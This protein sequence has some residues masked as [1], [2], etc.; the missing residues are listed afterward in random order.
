MPIN[1]ILHEMQTTLKVPKGQTNNFGKYKYRSCEDIVEA[2]KKA[3][4]DGYAFTLS[5]EIVMIG[6]RF[7]I[8]AQAL[9]F[10]DNNQIITYGYAREAET[11]KGMDSAQITG[12]A[13]SY[14]RK[15]ALNGLFAID[16]TKDAD[17]NEFR[18][19][20]IEAE[21]KAAAQEVND[22]RKKAE[23]WVNS[24]LASL[25]EIPSGV[26][27]T[28]EELMALQTVNAPALRKMSDVYP[29]LHEVITKET[30]KVRGV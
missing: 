10:G 21:K 26:G 5:D 8:K 3:L 6:D 22:N 28:T 7:Y 13:S 19:N 11:K 14:A 9:L 23:S 25:N 29:D 18:D 4:P 30:N 24:Y 12:A 17:T 15:Y 16:D 1:E 20:K 27:L 2:V